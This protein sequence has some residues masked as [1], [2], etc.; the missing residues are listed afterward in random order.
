MLLCS[1]ISIFIQERKLP[2]SSIFVLSEA[3][4]ANIEI[5]GFAGPVLQP[6]G[7]LKTGH[8]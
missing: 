3:F 2:D 4:E 1:F 8:F 7:L 6:A 5:T